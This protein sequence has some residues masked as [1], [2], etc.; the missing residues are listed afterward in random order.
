MKGKINIKYHWNLSDYPE[1]TIEQYDAL[2]EEAER[3]VFEMLADTY[4]EGELH[5]DD[6][7]DFRV[8]GWWS[9]SKESSNSGDSVD[10]LSHRLV[11]KQFKHKNGNVYTVIY[12]TNLGRSRRESIDHPIDVVYIGQNGKVWS[13]PLN[14]WWRSFN[15]VI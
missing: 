14:D 12:L 3:R 13:M 6:G 5:Y 1:I 2:E 10:D 7:E 11:G 9:L 15:Q 8:N 4:S